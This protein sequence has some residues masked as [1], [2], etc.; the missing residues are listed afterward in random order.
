M[1]G[2]NYRG[3][4][5]VASTQE[6]LDRFLVSDAKI[7]AGQCPNNCGPMR[8]VELLS[9]QRLP[10]LLQICPVCNFTTNTLKEEL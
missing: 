10:I 9:K 1:K 2:L 6:G 8:P 5:V 3:G 7:R 4:R